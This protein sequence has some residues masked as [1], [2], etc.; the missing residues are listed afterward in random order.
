M[1]HESL[2]WLWDTLLSAAVFSGLLLLLLF[3]SCLLCSFLK[4]N[5]LNTQCTPHSCFWLQYNQISSV[6]MQ[7]SK[8]KET[9]L[10][11][12]DSVWSE[13]DTA[14]AAGV[15][16]LTS[17]RSSDHRKRESGARAS[18]ER[19]PSHQ[20]IHI[21]RTS[22]TQNMKNTKKADEKISVPSY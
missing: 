21:H 6:N 9:R 17:I 13:C 19:S 16:I 14:G 4:K 12:S 22:E 2:T 3:S 8:K 1:L 18:R 15:W 11:I 20:L 10:I 5:F 7:M